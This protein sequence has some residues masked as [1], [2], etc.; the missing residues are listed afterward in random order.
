MR[1]EVWG[2]S[3]GTMS[4]PA[5]RAAWPGVDVIDLAT[6]GATARGL[7]RDVDCLAPRP[8]PAPV[9][10]WDGS[11]VYLSVGA[12]D[13][14]IWGLSAAEVAG[15]VEDI[16]REPLRAG[17]AVLHAGYNAPWFPDWVPLAQALQARQPRYA[18]VDMRHMD[19]LV[20][21]VDWGHLRPRDYG[22]R[23]NYCRRYWDAYGP[24]KLAR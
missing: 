21:L 23:A 20:Q 6:G 2:D 11:F 16:V 15:Y 8:N 12:L 18:Y 3:W 14:P 19:R 9:E 10:P 17:W 1:I 5:L 4:V 7:S 22:R 13:D 24:G